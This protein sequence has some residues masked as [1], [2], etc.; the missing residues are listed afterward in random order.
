LNLPGHFNSAATDTTKANKHTN[1]TILLDVK[2][3]WPTNSF[4]LRGRH[5]TYMPL[6]APWYFHGRQMLKYMNLMDGKA[7]MPNQAV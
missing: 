5:L 3:A 4:F 7:V 6:A 2:D 1:L